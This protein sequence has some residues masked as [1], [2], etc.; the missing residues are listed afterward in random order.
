MTQI[1]ITGIVLKKVEYG[2]RDLIITLLTHERG[3]QSFMI[4]GAR[5]R[6]IK[7]PQPVDL[8]RL[9]SIIYNERPNTTS[10]LHKPVSVELV[11]SFDQLA[12][13]IKYYE[14]ALWICRFAS[15][16]LQPEG[17]VPLFYKAI[18]NTL[19]TFANSNALPQGADSSFLI[20]TLICYLLEQGVIIPDMLGNQE[21]G[22]ALFLELVQNS[23]INAPTLLPD[24]KNEIFDWLEFY[25]KQLNCR[26]PEKLSCFL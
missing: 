8:F 25:L 17:E 23:E 15:L 24:S 21:T 10:D 14:K 5:K 1:T 22:L 16:N 20:G 9:L 18:L 11:E 12:S 2:E 3:L 7:K 4:K 6:S 13:N 19:R 26:L